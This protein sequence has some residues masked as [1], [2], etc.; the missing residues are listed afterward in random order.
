MNNTMTLSRGSSI[1]IGAFLIGTLLTFA[2]TVSMGWLLT[3]AGYGMLGVAQALL[4]IGGLFTSN[5]FPWV[6]AKFMAEPARQ[7]K[8]AIFKSSLLANVGLACLLCLLLYLSYEF[9]WLPLENV[10]QP[11]IIVIIIYVLIASVGA[12][13]RG[14][15]QG[16]L[17][18]KQ[19]GI[20]NC[21][22]PVLLLTASVTLV[23]LGFGA[24][25]AIS[26]FAIGALVSLIFLLY[27]TRDQ[28][29]W[30][31]SPW[32]NKEVYT[33][34]LP[35]FLGVMGAQFLMNV[36]I[37]GVK[38][39][40]PGMSD[41]MAGYYRAS[42]AISRMPVFFIITIMGA[43][44]PFIS[45]YASNRK[46]VNS[47]SAKMVKYVLIFI[48]PL[49]LAIFVI[50][51]SLI[52]LIFPES[53]IAGAS[54]LRILSI[55][56]LLLALSYIYASVFQGVGKPKIPAFIML[57]AIA[58]QIVCLYL[59]VP[60]Y[61][62]IGA[63][64]ST[65]SACSLAFILLQYMH[66]KHFGF[67][68]NVTDLGKTLLASIA[69]SPVLYF[70]PMPSRAL[71]V[72]GLVCGLGIFFTILVVTKVL[73]HT[74]ADILLSGLLDEESRFRSKVVNLVRILNREAVN[75]NPGHR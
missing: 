64:V 4:G 30:K 50:P 8:P 27:Y 35:M 22:Q 55:G 24:S 63:A 21:V 67:G 25:G 23:S 56:M 13:Y 28:R 51:E 72:V 49:C 31:G 34:A 45:Y 15:L 37:L 46:M 16:L 10:Y 39:F 44:L 5:A 14:S 18:F 43:F 59:L 65:T 36:D 20:V 29:L 1:L 70:F 40:I 11:L 52:T 71:T 60:R 58:I 19:V 53:Y 17:K 73:H 26:G 68:F 61:G 47:Y 3:P 54:A 2:F 9:R 32:V 33:F 69:L 74:D 38:F 12:I 66:A 57:G 62:L 75:L 6:V 42:L 7:D 41:T 48:L